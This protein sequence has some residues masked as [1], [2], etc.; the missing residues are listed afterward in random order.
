MATVRVD[1]KVLAGLLGGML[2]DVTGCKVLMPFQPEPD[3]YANLTVPIVYWRGLD[4]EHG[5][6][7]TKD[8]EPNS[9]LFTM[10]LSIVSPPGATKAGGWLLDTIVSRIADVF[11]DYEAQPGPG[12]HYLDGLE[13]SRSDVIDREHG[14]FRMCGMTISGVCWRQSG[15][16]LT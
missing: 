7:G 3:E 12:T 1:Q 6:G 13:W 14:Q 4:T 15:T 10:H 16:S 11:M 5:D 2:Q 8:G 9:V